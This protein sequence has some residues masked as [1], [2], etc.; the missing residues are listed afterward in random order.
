[1]QLQCDIGILGR[2]FRGPIH[3]HLIE[4]DF[5]RALAGE[6]FEVDGLD[7]EISHGARIHIVTRRDAVQDVGLQHG[8]EA[9]T[10]ERDAVVGQHVR[11]EFKMMAEFRLGH[12]LEHGLQCRQ[13]LVAIEL[14]RRAR[15][16]VPERH[17]RCLARRN[18]EGHPD[19]LRSHVVQT[20]GLGI[21]RNE[22]RGLQVSGA[23]PPVPPP[24]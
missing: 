20:V 7:A 22:R 9:L 16:V 1:M 8:V 10:I 23:T 17:V 19:D 18:R 14:M 24:T 6:L 2:I 21:E 13:H 11:V 5:L 12:V 4:G 3:V 15:V